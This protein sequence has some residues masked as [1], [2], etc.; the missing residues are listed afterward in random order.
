MVNIENDVIRAAVI[1]HP[2]RKRTIAALAETSEITINKLINGGDT[3]FT[4]KALDRIA[5]FLGYDVHVTFKPAN[6]EAAASN[7]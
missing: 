4:L 7:N 6:K 5:G 3:N 2:K 1:N